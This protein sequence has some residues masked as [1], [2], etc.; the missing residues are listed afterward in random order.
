MPYIKKY[1]LWKKLYESIN[2]K[3][4]AKFL[5][6]INVESGEPTS[7]VLNK[8]AATAYNK[9]KN[10][11]KLDGV[12]W[13]ITG[14][15]RTYETQV[16]LAKEKGLYSE[17]GLAAKPGTSKHGLGSAVDVNLYG[18]KTRRPYSDTQKQNREL[19]FNWLKANASRYGFTNIPR[20]P[21]HWEHNE[22]ANKLKSVNPT[23]E[24]M[25]QDTQY[26]NKN[27]LSKG[28][29]NDSPARWLAT[30]NPEIAKDLLSIETG[31][32]TYDLGS[33]T[34]GVSVIQARLSHLGY[35]ASPSKTGKYNKATKKAVSDFQKTFKLPQ[36]GIFD[37]ITY[38]YLYSLTSFKKMQ[39]GSS[40]NTQTS[41]NLPVTKVGSI[42]HNYVGSKKDNIE[43][44]IKAMDKN[45]ITNI[46]SQVAILSVVGK[47]CN[48]IP[49]NERMSYRK[50]R[51]PEVW[52][53][54]SK[55]GK[56]VKKGTGKDNF[57]KLALE[58]EKNDEKLANFVY[59]TVSGNSDHGDG[60]KYRGRGFN[61]ITGKSKYIDYS[62]LINADLVGNPDL[63]NDPRTSAKII[64]AY[65]LKQFKKVKEDINSPTS[66]NDAISLISHM[67]SGLGRRKTSTTV[68]RGINKAKKY[69]STFNYTEDNT[70]LV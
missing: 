53:V 70:G 69:A 8:V 3:V 67:N 39:P 63:V 35:L 33:S 49:K 27:I 23:I 51:L 32:A 31:K 4:P 46:Y 21:W 14:S 2:G 18:P 43:L 50:E 15:Y 66:L 25:V 10:A 17:G 65:F 68:I 36:T 61:G 30:S 20:E 9:M 60:W 38:L 59:K 12:I 19:T 16:R 26:F 45:G 42:E 28:L 41:N 44:L 40:G 57:N 13:G 64:C 54:F 55:T 7:H 1:T 52:G 56:R 5:F 62:K 6:K 48:Y 37:K 34:P 29:G 11:A 47:E 22:S 58:Y 24:P